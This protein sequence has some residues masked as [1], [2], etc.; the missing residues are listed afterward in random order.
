L[1]LKDIEVFYWT[2]NGTFG[3][4][5]A[6]SS[7]STSDTNVAGGGRMGKRRNARFGEIGKYLLYRKCSRDIHQ[8]KASLT[9]IRPIPINS[10]NLPV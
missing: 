10:T 6:R 7:Q 1:V 4:F 9:K 2:V 5:E 8:A 3:W